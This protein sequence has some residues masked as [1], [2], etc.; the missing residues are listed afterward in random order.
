MKAA[1]ALLL[2]L[3]LLPAARAADPPESIYA[4]F[5]RA[6]VAGD[7]NRMMLYAPAARRKEM[8]RLPPAQKAAQ[9]KLVAAML[10]RT[11]VVQAKTVDSEGLSLHVSGMSTPSKQGQKSEMVYGSIKMRLEGGD[12]K[13]GSMNWSNTPPTGAARGKPPAPSVAAV[14]PTGRYAIK[15]PGET[16]AKP[17]RATPARPSAAPMSRGGPT[18]VGAPPE[19]KLG[20]AKPPCVYKPAMT[21][22]DLE[23]CR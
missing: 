19:R 21:A 15:P 23:N 22:E 5:H 12:W 1:R 8:A 3:A 4:N 7:L 10:P 20:T 2:C 14:K 11:Y 18:V 16:A 6:A 9:V 13:V 17:P